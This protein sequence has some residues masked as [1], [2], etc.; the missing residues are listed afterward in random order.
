MNFFLSFFFP[1]HFSTSAFFFFL[2]NCLCGWAGWVFGGRREAFEDLYTSRILMKINA[3]YHFC[4]RLN[5]KKTPR[6]SALKKK[7]HPQLLIKATVI[8]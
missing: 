8:F 7:P 1:L 6:Y 3:F 4:F 5:N 2:K